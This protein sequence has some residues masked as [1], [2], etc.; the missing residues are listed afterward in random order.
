MGKTAVFGG[1]FNPIHNGHIHLIDT[2]IEKC[3]IDRMIVMPANIPPHKNIADNVSDEDRLNMCRIAVS[4]IPHTE[5]S[6]YEIRKND[7][8]YTVNTLRDFKLMYPDDELYFVMGSDMLLSFREWKDYKEILLLACLIVIPREKEIYKKLKEFSDRLISDG[9]KVVIV[10]A[11]PFVIS[12]TE[13]REKIKSNCNKIN[14]Y[15]PQD[16]VN[17]IKKKNIYMNKSGDILYTAEHYRQ[18]IKERLTKKRYAHSINVAEEAVKLAKKYNE[19]QENAYTAGLL[20]DICKELPIEKQKQMVEKS[21]LPMCLVERTSPPLWHGIAGAW[22]IENELNIKDIDIINA[23]RYHTS[24]RAGMSRLE[25]IIYIADLISADRTYK[26]VDRIRKLA[27]ASLGRTMLE[28]L[29]F[30]IADVI[31]KSSKLP[32]NT[33]EAYNQYS[34]IRN[35]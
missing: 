4:Q 22:F 16:V 6:D 34:V 18:I 31:A 3:G 21:T 11:E 10:D 7:I 32:L 33:V 35:D 30:S 17:Y 24:G 13:I 19:N 28:G 12:S 9:G 23:V 2:V 15:L 29:K 26:D 1:T 27:Y 5:V 8:S 14:F 25:E 20:H